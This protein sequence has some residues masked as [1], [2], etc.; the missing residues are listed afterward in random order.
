MF[1]FDFYPQ[2]H[3]IRKNMDGAYLVWRVCSNG[4]KDSKSKIHTD[5]HRPIHYHFGYV[6]FS[7]RFFG[8]VHYR[9]KIFGFDKRNRFISRYAESFPGDEASSEKGYLDQ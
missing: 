6:T 2:F 9:V 7:S 8:A 1:A 3:E 5:Y 4:R